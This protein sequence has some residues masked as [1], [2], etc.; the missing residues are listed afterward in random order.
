MPDGSVAN[1][2]KKWN[3][4]ECRWWQRHQWTK[5]EIVN[6]YFNI[7]DPRKHIIKYKMKRKCNRCGTI[8]FKFI[9]C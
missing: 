3:K 4:N 7:H 6:K 5:W 1:D 8:D 2:L 9:H